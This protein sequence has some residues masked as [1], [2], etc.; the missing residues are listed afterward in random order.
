MRSSDL[1]P[2]GRHAG[3]PGAARDPDRQAVH[4]PDRRRGETSTGSG[5]R[6][7]RTRPIEACSSG[8]A[9]SSTNGSSIG[10][11]RSTASAAASS[12]SRRS[13][14]TTSSRRIAIGP[15][16]G[17]STTHGRA[18]GPTALR[19]SSQLPADAHSPAATCRRRRTSCAARLRSYARTSRPGACELLPDLGEALLEKGD[20]DGRGRAS[21]RRAGCDRPSTIGSTRMPVC[22]GSWSNSTRAQTRDGLGV[23]RT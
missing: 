15:S 10:P 18:V 20:F 19:P 22:S 3:G 8:P 23:S 1:V 12:S 14:A 21:T 4:P 6:S 2:R 9:P 13:S 7:S 11:S 5:T 17:R 16:S